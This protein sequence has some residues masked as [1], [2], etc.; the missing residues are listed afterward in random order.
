[1]SLR[2]SVPGAVYLPLLGATVTTWGARARLGTRV[3]ALADVAGGPTCERAF[4]VLHGMWA[5]P[6]GLLA[7]W[8]GSTGRSGGRQHRGRR[9]C[10]AA[11][12]RL[13][14][15]AALAGGCK[16]EVALRLATRVTGGSRYVL[17]PLAGLWQPAGRRW[18]SAARFDAAANDAQPTLALRI[19]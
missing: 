14:G 5:A 7:A 11:G 9:A 4:D 6:P 3:A 16:V 12:D 15:A 10:R 1:M 13:W 19:S 17:A 8:P 2:S 18:A